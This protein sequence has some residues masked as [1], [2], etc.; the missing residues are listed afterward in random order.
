M[1]MR[2]VLLVATIAVLSCCATF[3]QNND[4]DIVAEVDAQGI[5]LH[6]LRNAGGQ[7]LAIMEEQSYRLKQQKLEKI[8]E[9]KLLEWEARRRGVSV[10]LLT[11][12]EITSKTPEVS[13][14]EIHN[15]YELNKDQ[16]QKPESELDGQIRS[17]LREQK[18]AARRREFT[19]SL[20]AKAKV[21]VYLTAPP[22]FR[23]EIA[24][25]GPSRGAEG[26][27]VTIVEFEDFQC[28]FCRKAQET[29]EHIL[30]RYDGK[31]RMVHRDFPLQALHA[32]AWKA[33]EASHCAEQQGKF[34]EYRALLYKNAAAVSLEQLKTDAVQLGMSLPDFAKCLETGKF[35]TVVQSDEDEGNRLGVQGTPAFFINGRLLSGAQ[36]E[37]EFA[38][39]IDE[40]LA[41]RAQR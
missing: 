37:S 15:V 39:I 33:H 12:T 7:A 10:E 16:L 31:V 21:S 23:A 4:G 26:A 19:K 29:L 41:K 28:P 17:L 11:E 1:V 30:T 24:G 3:A 25:D 13:A 38:R 6:E 9:D 2:R 8:I 27:P 20:Q 34:W 5:S 32:A 36:S 35:K 14:A 18:V 22:P 40:E